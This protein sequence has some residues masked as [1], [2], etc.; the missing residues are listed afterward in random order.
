M[1][2]IGKGYPDTTL[3]MFG[4]ANEGAGDTNLGV[5][6]STNAKTFLNAQGAPPRYVPNPTITR[7]FGASH[8][9]TGILAENMT[10][11]KSTGTVRLT[12][13]DVF[14]P[15]AINLAFCTDPEDLAPQVYAIKNFCVPYCRQLHEN[16]KTRYVDNSPALVASAKLLTENVVKIGATSLIKKISWNNDGTILIETTQTR[17]IGAPI[18]TDYSKH[19]WDDG[20]VVQIFPRYQYKT[21]GIVSKYNVV[22][23]DVVQNCYDFDLNQ[24]NTRSFGNDWD[25]VL[26]IANY[27]NNVAEHSDAQGS[28]D[29]MWEQ[30]IDNTGKVIDPNNANY[31]KLLNS[32]KSDL[33]VKQYNILKTNDPSSGFAWTKFMFDSG[34]S[35][36]RYGK[37]YRV[38]V[39]DDT[40]VSLVQTVLDG[41]TNVSKPNDFNAPDY[42]A[43]LE[44]VNTHLELGAPGI[45]D[46][47]LKIGQCQK[48]ISPADPQAQQLGG[49]M[50]FPY[51]HT[52]VNDP[53]SGILPV[54][55]GQ[56]VLLKDLGKYGNFAG[57]TN[58]PNNESINDHMI[59][60]DLVALHR[61][62]VP[63][64]FFQLPNGT[65]RWYK[66]DNTVSWNTYAESLV[67]NNNACNMIRNYDSNLNILF[68]GA[69][70]NNC[71]SKMS[72]CDKTNIVFN[73]PLEVQ[74]NESKWNINRLRDAIYQTLWGHHAMGTCKMGLESD[75]L[76][77]VDQ[78][79]RVFNISG[80]RIA[81]CSIL[82]AYSANTMPGA[83]LAGERIADF[84]K[85]DYVELRHQYHCKNKSQVPNDFILSNSNYNQF[86]HFD[87][88]ADIPLTSNVRQ[89]FGSNNANLRNHPDAGYYIV[90]TPNGQDL[91]DDNQITKQTNYVLDWSKISPSTH[92]K[93]WSVVNNI[94]ETGSE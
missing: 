38:K 48:Y 5:T 76:S 36:L 44:D 23:D 89:L 22:E 1:D 10:G 54:V 66:Q 47:F 78:M 11:I 56:Y 60:D 4:V 8:T 13:N 59:D 31:L 91:P 52:C 18:G 45:S 80:L 70:N 20:D 75:P 42:I 26:R 16:P 35:N 39:I 40:H 90:Q 27:V 77:V 86:H 33:T 12:S 74:V 9:L 32:K 63:D 6:T 7:P 94:Q 53:T 85:R 34:I 37:L 68:G 92:E 57:F 17:E 51:I 2:C 88:L 81:D 41:G 72:Y 62:D 19:Y 14:S 67:S 21:K 79:G 15:P 24:V 30:F 93:G 87:N 83:I 64:H 3:D 50:P 46:W 69:V 49:F 73:V 28:L 71:V 55:G 58:G 84:M 29:I 25:N 82:P 65:R 43:N 61:N